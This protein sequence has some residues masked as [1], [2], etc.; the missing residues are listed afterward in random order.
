LRIDVLL[1]SL[2]LFKT[3][4]Q[5]ARACAD[6]RVWLNDQQVRASRIVRPGDKIRWRDPLGRFEQEV[7]ILEVPAGQVSRTAARGMVREIAK[8]AIDDPWVA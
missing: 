4:S 7:E 6:G 3:R 8:R 5:A 1:H 2:C